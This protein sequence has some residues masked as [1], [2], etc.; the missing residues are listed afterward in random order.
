[1]S[2]W[3]LQLLRPPH[4]AAFPLP[5][6][7]GAALRNPRFQWA[8]S[9]LAHLF[10]GGVYGGRRISFRQ[11]NRIPIQQRFCDL[12]CLFAEAEKLRLPPEEEASRDT[13]GFEQI[14]PW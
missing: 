9:F 6:C 11:F 4:L 3:N 7:L 10:W 14:D 2:M 8:S 5:K 12:G 1:M 13:Q